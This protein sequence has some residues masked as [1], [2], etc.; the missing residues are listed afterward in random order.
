MV[1]VKE[2]RRHREAAQKA[3]K[4]IRSQKRKT[5]A[6]KTGKITTFALQE[7]KPPATELP[8]AKEKLECHW[9]GNR[10][11]VPFDKSPPDISCGRFWELRWAY[12]CPFN[13]S[14]CY[15][16]GTMRGKMKPQF[17]RTEL[18]LQA[19]DDA[20]AKITNPII[21]NSGELSDSLMNPPLMEP[22]VDKFE[23]QNLHKIYLLT[24]CGMKNI[25]FL[26]N[27]SRKQVICGWS[28][29]AKEVA[30]KW[31]TGAAIPED[32]IHAA[33]LAS[34]YDYDTRIRIDP[35]FPIDDWK[36]KYSDLI[37]LIFSNFT[38]SKI[39]LG[40]PRGLWKTIHYA[41]EA[42]ADIEWVD[43]FGEDS[44]WGKKLVFKQRKEIYEFFLEKL[45]AAG[46]PR[47][48]IS[49]C[50]ETI[51]LW[52]ALELNAVSGSCNCYGSQALK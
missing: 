13:C 26:I 24:K 50:K 17:V 7:N 4:T 37:D 27:K 31:E 18:V 15:L 11:V 51:E 25:N 22:I 45:L 14:Y 42:N 35:I 5:G 29:N 28:I 33:T 48:N 23:E 21:F 47:A 12:G 19:L 43:F 8:V 41:K 9:T 2:K 6:F 16:R 46:Y 40:T 36:K 20:F 52:K 39:I 38:P 44:S 34:D 3:W 32:R 1:K 30:E 49:M 10:I